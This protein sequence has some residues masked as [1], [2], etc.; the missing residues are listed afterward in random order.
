MT[1][2]GPL[3][4]LFVVAALPFALVCCT[5]AP[6]PSTSDPISRLIP[7]PDANPEPFLIADAGASAATLDAAIA[8]APSEAGV[9]SV[10]HPIDESNAVLCAA[11][12]RDFSAL[13]KKSRGCSVDT[14]CVELFTS[15]GLGRPCGMAVAKHAKAKLEAIDERYSKRNCRA[16][17]GAPC[18]TCL[19]PKPPTC[20]AGACE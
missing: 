5:R 4:A 20:V 2:F 16:I 19:P 11:T 9:T 3:S 13:V 12:M 8:A 10:P 18:A 14:D 7:N 17:T 15:C 6:P 1:T